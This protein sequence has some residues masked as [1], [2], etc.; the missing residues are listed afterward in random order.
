MPDDLKQAVSTLTDKMISWRRDFHRHPEIGLKE[1]RTAGIVAGHLEKLGLEVQTCIGETGVVGLLEGNRPGKTLMLRADMDALPIQEVNN[2]PYRSINNNLM[3]ACAHDGHTAIL[4]AVAEL[5][6]GRGYDFSG[7]VKFVFQPGEEGAGGAVKMINDGV[8]E[9]PV[10]DAILALHIFSVLPVGTVGV[11][12]GAFMAGADRYNIKVLG[13]AGHGATPETAVDA[14]MISGHVLTSLQSLVS[15]EIS[16]QDQVVITIGQIE[17]GLAPNII[18]DE[19]TLRASVRT[20]SERTRESIPERLDRIVGGITSAFRG[21]HE[22]EHLGGVGPVLN[23]P[24]LAGIVRDVAVSVVGDEM[25]I[26]MRPIMGSDDLARFFEFAPGCYFGIGG[27]NKEKDFNH[28]HHHPRFDFDEDAL[29]IGAE[30]LSRVLQMVGRKIGCRIWHSN[31][32]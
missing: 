10:V 13:E 9:N 31:I 26:E 2:V 5:L 1:T 6:V 20:M 32:W 17:G 28:P 30:T 8:M 22:V 14:I 27:R 23:Q 11:R 24:E 19:V 3:H 4:M 16:A 21:R 15:R 18:C 29:S 12:S 7:K 25:V